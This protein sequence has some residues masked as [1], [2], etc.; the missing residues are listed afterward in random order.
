MKDLNDSERSTDKNRVET[1][2]NQVNLVD[3]S[4]EETVEDDER[5]LVDKPKRVT[6]FTNEKLLKIINQRK[7]AG[8]GDLSFSMET[9][10]YNYYL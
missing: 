9:T 6:L 8:D 5:D 2:E 1:S 10:L 3:Y 7:C 4:S